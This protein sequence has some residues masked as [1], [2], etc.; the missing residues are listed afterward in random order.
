MNARKIKLPHALIAVESHFTQYTD[1]LNAIQALQLQ[2][3]CNTHKDAEDQSSLSP[4]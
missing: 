1:T 4:V 2:I 3:P